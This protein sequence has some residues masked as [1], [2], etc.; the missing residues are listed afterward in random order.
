[1]S[2]V[3]TWNITI[4]ELTEPSGGIHPNTTYAS[5]IFAPNTIIEVCDLW[6]ENIGDA[7]GTINWVLYES[8][9]GGGWIPLD[10]GSHN[11]GA[12]SVSHVGSL[13]QQTPSD[14]GPWNLCVVVWAD[15][16]ENE[17]SCGTLSLKIGNGVY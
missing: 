11:L 12:G 5:G 10:N 13:N 1:M 4:E 6:V 17:P 14:E 9:P 3:H 15:G 2:D 8:Y 7:A 16:Y